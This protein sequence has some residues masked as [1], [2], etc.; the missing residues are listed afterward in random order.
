MI[1]LPSRRKH[2][3]PGGGVCTKW[4]EEQTGTDYWQ[5]NGSQYSQRFEGSTLSGPAQ[6]CE[7][8]VWIRSQSGT[9]DCTFEFWD[10]NDRGAGGA[11]QIG[12][13]SDNSGSVTST[14]T[15]VEITFPT[16][17]TLP[18]DDDIYL[19]VIPATGNI[20]WNSNPSASPGSFGVYNQNGQVGTTNLFRHE[21]WLDL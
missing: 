5:P 3:Q 14:P 11:A 8:H 6:V 16:Y 13:S 18:A 20:R 4:S 12:A 10:N 9:A 17:P 1:V 2:H 15:K 21:L 7:L 19:H